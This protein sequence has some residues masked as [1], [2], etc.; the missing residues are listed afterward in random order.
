MYNLKWYIQLM[1]MIRVERLFQK[2]DF[3]GEIF[4]PEKVNESLIHEYLLLQTANARNVI[5][6]TKT[7]S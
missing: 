6:S 5:A 4:A 1:Y 3:N 2:F 7:M